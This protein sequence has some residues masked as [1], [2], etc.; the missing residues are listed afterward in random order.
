MTKEGVAEV[1]EEHKLCFTLP[2]SLQKETVCPCLG[3]IKY[4]FS[5]SGCSAEI[6]L[7]QPT[8]DSYSSYKHSELPGTNYAHSMTNVSLCSSGFPLLAFLS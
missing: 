2:P 6:S 1:A 4:S 7:Y 5:V 8:L 3:N